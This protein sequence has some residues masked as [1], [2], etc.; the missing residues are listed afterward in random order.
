M[1]KGGW[2]TTEV[3]SIQPTEKS[4]RQPTLTP[5]FTIGTLRKAIP[6]HCFKRSLVT[7]SAYLT[8]NLAAVAAL[9]IYSTTIDGLPVWARLILWPA[10]WFCQGAVCTGVWVIAHECG[11]QAFSESQA[12]NDT[13]GLVLHSCLLV[14]YYSWKHSH[15]RHHSNTGNCSKD[16]VF[17]PDLMPAD[18]EEM[19]IRDLGPVRLLELLF[20]LTLGWPMYLFMNSSGRQYEGW[21]NHFSPYS[22]IYSPRER[23]EILISDLALGLAAAGLCWLGSTYGWLWLV[24]VYVVPYLWV[25]AWLVCITLLQH[26]HPALPHYSDTEW[27]WLRGAL[28]TVDRSYGPLDIVFHHIADTHVAHHLFSTMP[29]YHAQE[30]TRA[31]IPVLGKYYMRDERNVLRALWEDRQACRWVSPDKDTPSSGVMWFRSFKNFSKSE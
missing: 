1:G 25:N 30:A 20:V 23:K 4:K 31:L 13:V 5:P 16:E 7:S 24:K 6:Q 27:D 2:A 14:P 21:A 9:Y 29:H 17:V 15:R 3:Y 19:S 18:H 8:A 26:T 28:S 12:V 10:Y 11:H 22:P